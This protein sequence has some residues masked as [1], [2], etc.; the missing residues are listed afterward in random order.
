MYVCCFFLNRMF[1]K[2]HVYGVK[3]MHTINRQVVAIRLHEFKSGLFLTT[4][5]KTHHLIFVDPEFHCKLQIYLDNLSI[6]KLSSGASNLC[7]RNIKP[8]I[9]VNVYTLILA[10]SN[11]STSHYMIS[12]VHLFSFFECHHVFAFLIVK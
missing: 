4:L 5:C 7:D 2:A 8:H 3:L 6:P 12:H 11:V 9:I 10:Y 1:Y